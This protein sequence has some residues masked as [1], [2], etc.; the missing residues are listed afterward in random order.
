MLGNIKRMNLMASFPALW[1]AGS[2]LIRETGPERAGDELVLAQQV[3]ESG[4]ESGFCWWMWC[5]QDSTNV[6][7]EGGAASWWLPRPPA[8]FF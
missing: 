7:R 4:V 2:I 3:T 6:S 1:E 8:S 5:R